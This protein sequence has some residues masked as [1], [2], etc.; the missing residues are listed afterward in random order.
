MRRRDVLVFGI[1]MVVCSIIFHEAVHGIIFRYFGC[2]DV[3]YGI[4]LMYFYTRCADEEFVCSDQCWLA[5]SVN[6]IVGYTIVPHLV[7]LE[8][9]LFIITRKQGEQYGKK[10]QTPRR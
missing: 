10:K 8:V 7:L 9:A 5:H 2:K 3:R 6:E 1:L 4:T